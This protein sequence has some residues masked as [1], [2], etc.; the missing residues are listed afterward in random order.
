MDSTFHSTDPNLLGYLCVDSFLKNPIG[1]SALRYCFSRGWIERWILEGKIL[2]EA[3]PPNGPVL[4][5][6]LIEEGV[7]FEEDGI[8]ALTT[9]FRQAWKYSDLMA[10]KLEFCHQIISDLGSFDLWMEDPLEFQKHSKLFRLF[11]YGKCIELTERNVQ[12]TT[13]WVRLTTALSR[14]EAPLFLDSV[15]WSSHRN[16][17]DLGGNSG[18]FAMQICRRFQQLKATVMDLP[19]VCHLGKMHVDS[20]GMSERVVFKAGDF[21]QPLHGPQF[22]LVSFKSVLHDWPQEHAVDLIRQAWDKLLPGGRLLIIERAKLPDA[23]IRV[24]LGHAPVWMFWN[25]YRIPNFYESILLKHHRVSMETKILSADM[26]RMVLQAI[27][28]SR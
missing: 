9:A 16:W 23:S 26:P 5:R 13:S 18:E 20:F 2:L 10:T 21:L 7:V 8:L 1:V 19:V 12:A 17:L 4:V 28:S 15:D 14:Y 11:D 22:D 6:I 25:H 3:L 24:G 27:K